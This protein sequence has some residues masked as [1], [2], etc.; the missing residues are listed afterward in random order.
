MHLLGEKRELLCNQISA[1][2]MPDNDKKLL[3]LLLVTVNGL[4]SI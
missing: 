3:F 2:N 4:K 1:E